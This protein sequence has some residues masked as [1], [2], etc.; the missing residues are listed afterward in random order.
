MQTYVGSSALA[1][2]TEQPVPA[3]QNW[4]LN[5]TVFL[6]PDTTSQAQF[7]HLLSGLYSS[8]MVHTMQLSL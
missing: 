6:Q 5:V 1:Q 7:F 3:G 4:A 8:D 2:L